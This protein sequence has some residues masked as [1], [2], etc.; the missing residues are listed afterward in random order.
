[1]FT[2]VVKKMVEITNLYNLDIYT[3]AGQYVG[4]IVDIVLNIKMGTISKLQVESLEPTDKN[5]GMLQMLKKGLEFV[6]EEDD[7]RTY[8]GVLNID[9]DKVRAIGDIMLID[10]KD[11][12]RQAPSQQS[13]IPPQQVQ[14][15][16]QEHNSPI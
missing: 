4:R 1:V 3:M 7:M 10:P 15:I 8:Q 9:F 6:P 13:Q 11:I 12:Q 14:N 5:V 2:N 16:N